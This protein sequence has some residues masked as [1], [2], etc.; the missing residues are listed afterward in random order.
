MYMQTVQVLVTKDG[1]ICFNGGDIRL[2]QNREIWI[3]NK[4]VKPE[5]VVGHFS[6]KLPDNFDLY[7][8]TPESRKIV[9]EILKKGKEIAGMNKKKGKNLGKFGEPKKPKFTKRHF[10][11]TAKMVSDMPEPMRRKWAEQKAKEYAAGNPQF[12]RTKFMKACGV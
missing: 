11:D 10:I 1:T 2:S 9:V 6:V 5:E 3:I 8:G 7:G 4:S 12:D